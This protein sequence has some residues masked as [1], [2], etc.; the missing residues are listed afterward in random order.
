M[1]AHCLKPLRLWGTLTHNGLYQSSMGSEVADTQIHNGSWP[2]SSFR[3][4]ANQDFVFSEPTAIHFR[5]F[6]DVWES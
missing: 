4:A 3:H 2:E 6:V 5:I 1:T